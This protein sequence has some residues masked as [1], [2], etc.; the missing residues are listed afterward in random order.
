MKNPKPIAYRVKFVRDDDSQ[1]EE[2]N[3]E[4][5]PFTE[6][7]YKGNE[8]QKDGK[9]VSYADYRA[10]YGNPD[11]HVYLGAIVEKQCACCQS[12]TV[13]GSLWR[14][15][16]MDDSIECQTVSLDRYM[17][18]ID[19]LKLPGYLAEVARELLAEAGYKA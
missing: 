9:D 17:A 4:A 10:Y 16:F 8:Y 5:R 14:L 12:W 15:D 2:S 19:A 18:P 11:R 13:A 7:E 6:A 3:G 1:F